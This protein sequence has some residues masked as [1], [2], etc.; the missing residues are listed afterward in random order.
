MTSFESFEM[1]SDFLLDIVVLARLAKLA[2][3]RW[4]NHLKMESVPN[5][6]KRACN[7]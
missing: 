1:L 5:R 3:R 2:P 6:G 7:G 4:D